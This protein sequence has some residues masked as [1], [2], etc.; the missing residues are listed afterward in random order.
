MNKNIVT[1]I[2]VLG[3]CA[4]ATVLVYTT[5]VDDAPPS[6]VAIVDCVELISAADSIEMLDHARAR[7]IG[8]DCPPDQ[9]VEYIRA[10]LLKRGGILN[11]NRMMLAIELLAANP[12]SI[13]LVTESDI[14]DSVGFFI[15]TKVHALAR[16]EWGKLDKYKDE[17]A[18]EARA[19]LPSD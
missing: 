18:S 9:L 2:L 11:R 15:D 10:L 19:N 3:A 7:L 8:S 12:R 16:E 5:S 13:D 6:P 4:A 1:S 17:K 14:E